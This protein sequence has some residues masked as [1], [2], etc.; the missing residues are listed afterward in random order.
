[1]LV[2]FMLAM[3]HGAHAQWVRYTYSLWEEGD[4]AFVRKGTYD[5]YYNAK[6]T[7][8]PYGFPWVAATNIDGYC[9]SSGVAEY[10]GKTIGWMVGYT[11]DVSFISTYDFRANAAWSVYY[12]KAAGDGSYGTDFDCSN[13]PFNVYGYHVFFARAPQ[14]QRRFTGGLVVGDRLLCGTGILVNNCEWYYIYQ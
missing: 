1:M 6:L 12:Y 8:P 5:L 3:P 13:H 14:Y 4:P 7:T 10:G 2:L 11:T 9:N